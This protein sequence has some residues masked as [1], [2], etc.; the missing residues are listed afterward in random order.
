MSTHRGRPSTF[1]EILTDLAAAGRPVT[2]QA[3]M[4]VMI[5]EMNHFLGTDI[6]ATPRPMPEQTDAERRRDIEET[7]AVFNKAGGW[8]AEQL[9][10]NRGP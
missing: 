1:E 7:L 6:Q 4:M 9:Y 5:D 2:V 3:A 10:R 8:L